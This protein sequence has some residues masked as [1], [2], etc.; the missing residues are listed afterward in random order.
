MVSGKIYIHTIAL[1]KIE[2]L[3]IIAFLI[4]KYIGSCGNYFGLGARFGA[5]AIN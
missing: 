3:V 4:H 5:L 2:E 1:I